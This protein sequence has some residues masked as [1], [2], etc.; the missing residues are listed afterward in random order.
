MSKR[1]PPKR[2]V[3]GPTPVQ[4][5]LAPQERDRLERLA[6]R[7][8]TSKSEV[9]RRGLTALEDQLTDPSAHPVLRLVGS[10]EERGDGA[11]AA[12]DHDRVLGESEETAWGDRAR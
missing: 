1:K 11:D 2:R 12:R 8:D 10:A 3:S 9:L 7:L 5:Y 6:T 4:V